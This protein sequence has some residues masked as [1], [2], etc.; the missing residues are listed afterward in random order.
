MI[1]SIV[2]HYRV[3]EKL[4]SGGMGIVYRAEDI[5]LRRP[6]A[7][8]FLP[9]QLTTNRQALDRFL[10]EAR[11]AGAVNHP[12]ICTIYEV[13]EHE[14]RHFIV[15]ELLEG[16]TLKHYMA[17]R[18]LPKE[19][20]VEL[21]MEIAEALDAAHGK[22]IIH[23]DIKPANIFVT[24]RGQAKVL[25][26]GLAKLLNDGARQLETEPGSANDA[27]IQ[28]E[29]T[30]RGCTV[31]TAEYMS[32][33]Q[34]RGQDLDPRSDL[35]SLGAVLYEMATGRRAFSGQTAA[36][37]HEAILN[38]AP[39][40]PAP[41][42][43]IPPRLQEIIEKA[44]DKDRE[45]RYQSAN[46]LR[47]DL[48]R[49]KRDSET[50][51][52]QRTH[53]SSTVAAARMW[54]RRKGELAIAAIALSAIAAIFAW[55]WRPRP[56]APEAHRLLQRNITANSPENPVYA[57]AISPNGKYLAYAD[58][59]GVFVRLF[60]TGETHPL[61]L[62]EGFCFRCASLSWFQ[63]GTKLA[64][65]GPGQSGE[66][67]GI[68]AISIL[69]GSPR[70][71]RDDAGRAAVSP[72]GMH[73]AYIGNKTETEIWVM[74]ANGENP[75]ELVQCSQGDRFLQLQWSPDGKRVGYLKSRA[76]NDNAETVIESVPQGG[77]T[78]STILAAPGLRSF[79]WSSDGRII[80][81]MQELPPNERDSNLWEQRVNS[82]GTKA[83]GA[84]QR[85]TN[86]A[87]LSVSDLS[88][89]VD[90]QHLVFVNAGLQSDLYVAALEAK[91]ALGTPRRLTN[92]GRNNVPSAW[93]ADGH[94][95][96]FYSDRSGNWD[97]F[98][99]G[100]QETNSQDFVLGSGEQTEP[101]LSSDGLWILYW[102]YAEKEGGAPTRMRLL[103]V[104]ISGGAPELVL[105][106]N[107]GATVRCT[108]KVPRCVLSES[109]K[110]NGKLVFTAFD[111]M[112][113]KSGELLAVSIDPGASPAWDL[114][115]DGTSLAMVD[116]D[117]HKDFVRYVE[118]KA[119]DGAGWF[120]T[121]S[122]LRGAGIFYVPLHGG[123][124]K[125]LT[126]KANLGTPLAS[127][128]GKNLSFTISS[129][130]SNAWVIEN[131]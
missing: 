47:T 22:G 111:L 69:G 62:P 84:P 83:S 63:D 123:I 78:A 50:S 30:D 109:D 20:V 16:K 60:E 118:L 131:F 51:E 1:G 129:Y 126:S 80:Y 45:L 7:L 59:N 19:E 28:D 115:P 11:A 73:V 5:V 21:G 130:N 32:P 125:L 101:R 3:I 42:I 88:I 57:A 71:L 76:A 48:K 41:H 75:R 102:D 17:G 100:L 93:T 99:Q 40:P 81:S 70:K 82:S 107:R 9:E 90:S 2:T 53:S 38:R 127:P 94:G 12:C 121:S 46:E 85:I 43:E 39:A 113:G 96:F 114:S 91:G 56:R 77:G 23:R 68:W 33:E 61:T 86:W 89:S 4:G 18:P 95:I 36:V 122:S 44:L 64:A 112:R 92:Q 15:M 72:E 10:R 13:G 97:I 49:L 117:E 119:A 6:V 52:A 65:V 34:V 104:P 26:F 25:D 27:T 37:I 108:H 124:S 54:P 55:W 35:F 29:L 116:L 103:R 87:G 14:E 31:G 58:F 98:R 66:T 67:T 24:K 8:K 105:E 128:D 120:V 110:E 74:D 79:W 106:A